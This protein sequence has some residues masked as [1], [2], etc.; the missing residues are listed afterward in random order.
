MELK[1]YDRMGGKGDLGR[2]YK[3]GRMEV[4]GM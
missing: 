2:M 1:L 4:D 3:D